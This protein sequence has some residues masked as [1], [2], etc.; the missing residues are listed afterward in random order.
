[1]TGPWD[2]RRQ[3][4][5]DRGR[6]GRGQGCEATD[7]LLVCGVLLAGGGRLDEEEGF[8]GGVVVRVGLLGEGEVVGLEKR[9]LVGAVSWGFV[10]GRGVVPWRLGVV[11]VRRRGVRVEREGRRRRVVQ[12]MGFFGGLGV[13]NGGLGGAMR[14]GWNGCFF[15][16]LVWKDYV[17]R[18]AFYVVWVSTER[19][20]SGI[21]IADAFDHP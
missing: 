21:L 20:I 12:N 11:V 18:D 9:F 17:S 4:E 19:K 6:R 1:M 16:F 14:D 8:F 15:F 7:S 13:W 5:Q 2:R 3:Q 10:V